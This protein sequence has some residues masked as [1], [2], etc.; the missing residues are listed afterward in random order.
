MGSVNAVE[1]VAH[2]RVADQVVLDQI[3]DQLGVCCACAAP[4][5]FFLSSSITVCRVKGE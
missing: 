2:A 3:C 4:G 5:H 1:C